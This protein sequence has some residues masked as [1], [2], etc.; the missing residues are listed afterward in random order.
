[1]WYISVFDAKKD[2]TI[3]DIEKNRQEWVDQH[4]D[5]AIAKRCHTFQ[6][7]EVLG[8]TPL[9]VFF[10]IETDDPGALNLLSRYFGDTWDSVT[11]PVTK[12]E[13]YEA[14]TDDHAIIGG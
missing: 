8:K 3:N 12:R 10:I 11:Y 9:K 2:A 7:Y 1:M 13:I 14:L 4:K 5:Q 6:R